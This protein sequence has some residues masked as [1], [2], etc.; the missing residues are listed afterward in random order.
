MLESRTSW[1]SQLAGSAFTMGSTTECP[2]APF[3]KLGPSVYMQDPTGPGSGN[4]RP[5]IFIAFWMN[6]PP[7]ALAKLAVEYRHIAPMARIV[8]VRSSVGD[9][10]WRGTA[11]AQQARLAPAVEAIRV[12]A[13]RENPVFM[14][15]FSNSG[16]TSTIHFLQSY[17]KITGKPL[18]MSSMVLDSTPGTATVSAAMTAFAYA[19]PKM[20]I[21]RLITK[22]LSWLCLVLIKAFHAI[23][24]SPDPIAFA[25][26]VINYASLIEAVNVNGVPT[27]CYIYSDTDELVNAHDVEQHASH[28]EASGWAV[29]LERFQGTPHL[30]HRRAAPE[31][32]WDII[33]EYLELP[34]A[35]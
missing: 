2:L 25:R 35:T 16:L 17:L 12:L 27:R 31:R 34:A 32:Y 10:F 33:K 14:H 23:T 8:L 30:G 18:P 22:S 11:R 13:S 9:Y 26:R 3:V 5:L 15:L 28:S 20:W 21:L 29:R 7:R 4:C 1:K 6:A 24:R 19:L